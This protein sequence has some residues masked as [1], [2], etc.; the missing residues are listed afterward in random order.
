MGPYRSD[1]IAALLEQKNNLTCEECYAIHYDVY[2]VQA[3]AFMKILLP[4]LPD[5]PSAGIL[6]D[7]N[8]QYTADSKGA[9]LFKRFYKAL[10]QEVFGKNGLGEAVVSNLDQAT[11]IFNDFYAN[12][13]RIMLSSSSAW[14][15][16]RS[17]DEIYSQSAAAALSVEP[18][19]WG[20]SQQLMLENIFFGGKLPRFLGFDRGP[21]T[22]IG[23]LA[24]PHQGQI[25][26]SAGRKTSF[27]PSYRM[28]TDM[29]FNELHTNMSGGPSDRR[30]SR[31]YCSDL[32]NWTA[33]RYKRLRPDGTE[34]KQ[35]F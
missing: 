13:D 23:D 34:K 3:A 11:G 17:R 21:I 1:R 7:W 35:P 16:G 15:G 31:W 28:V 5:T 29:A 20:E 30:F 14:F 12:F 33:G 4:L 10:Y 18:K 6:K 9:W 22:I 32:A 25:Y 8:L 26:E 19:T 2:S 27:A 24:T